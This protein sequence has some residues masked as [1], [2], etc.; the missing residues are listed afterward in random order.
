VPIAQDVSDREA[1][2]TSGATTGGL[3][4][5]VR[6]RGG[7]EAVAEVLRRAGVPFTAEQLE[8]AGTWTGYDTRIR[9]FAAAT[10]VL[11]DPRTMFR[12]G[13]EALS[14]GLSPGITMLIRAIGSPR[15]VYR[16]LPRAVA[17][18]STTSVMSI[19]ESGAT[20]ATIRYEL[21]DGYRH[22]RL[23]CDYAV[24]LIGTIP[25]VFGL[26]DASVLHNEC[27]SDGFEACIYHV[28]WEERRRLPWRRRDGGTAESELT[29]LRNQLRALQTAASDLVASDDLSSALQQI[30]TRAAE[31]VLAPAYLL[32]VSSPS[33][34]APLVHSAGIPDD[35]LPALTRT[36]LA[37]GDLGPN[38]V[39]VDVVS[40]RR[41]YGRLAAVYR[42]G[43]GA[44][45]DERS[46]LSAYAG[47]AAAAL[48]L[49]VAVEDARLEAARA[50]ALLS[51]A[52]A[53]ASASDAEAVCRVVAD[54]L[55]GVVD[56]RRASIMLWDPAEG[57]LRTRASVGMDEEQTRVLMTTRLRAED[58][59]ELVGMLTDRAPRVMH[60]Q[61]SS[62]ALA[63]LLEGIGSADV[64]CVPL[65]AGGTFLGVAAVGWPDGEAPASLR[66]DVLARLQGVG[67]QA[68][69]AL[70]KARLLETVRH[71]A[72]H[73]ALT[74]LPNRVL[75]VERLES[76]L[77]GLPATGSLGVLFCDLDRFKAVN[78]TLGHAAGDELLRQVAA[79]LGGSVRPEDTVGRLSGDEFAVLL[80]GLAAAGD[81]A[82]LADRVTG[83]F[84]EP[85]R[86]DGEQVRV[87]TSVGI[88]VHTGPGGT[89]KELMRVADA[90]MYRHKQ[91]RRGP[92]PTA[93]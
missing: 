43:D 28:T 23:D 37:G 48:D 67:D 74:G 54:A 76:A 17:K 55:P 9:L 72:T 64:V 59:P 62:P 32:A 77:A 22:S 70:Q 3:L 60:Q 24:G 73:D 75:F 33:G 50:G 57:I 89:V 51:L 93:G 36:L 42:P 4:R 88:A 7:D 29:A 13:R 80:P 25:G 16:Q 66:G 52:H 2:E 44:L 61:S 31:A 53:L 82:A 71:Q 14:S 90:G 30:V 11:G 87:E 86:L 41:R 79:R 69:T 47:H 35:D 20:S 21:R 27:E 40:A 15:Q 68:S 58:T 83:C 8:E 45:G 49:L 26:P 85:F 81:A 6:A 1:R 65:L 84:D 91:H 78:D 19:V 92:E 34:G 18:F 56:C 5:Y 38:A 12:V 39:A 10:E 63:R 46:M